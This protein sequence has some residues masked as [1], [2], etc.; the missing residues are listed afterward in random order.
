MRQTSH[1]SHDGAH[2]FNRTAVD[3]FGTVAMLILAVASLVLYFKLTSSGLLGERYLLLIMIGLIAVNV[4]HIVVQVPL[5]RNKLGKL[6]CGVLAVILSAG[7]FWF[8]SDMGNAIDKLDQILGKKLV[9]NREIAVLVRMDDPAQD[10][11]DTFGYRYGYVEGLNAEDTNDLLQHLKEQLGDF[12][13]SASPNPTALVDALYS[14][15]VDAI[16]LPSGAMTQLA[17]MDEYADLEEKT[18]IIYTHTISREV[19]IAV[20]GAEITEP[21]VIYCNGIDSRKSDIHATGNSDVNILAVVNPK[22]REI[23]LLNTPRD[24]YVPLHMNGQN[25][26]LTHAGNYGIEESIGTLSDLYGVEVPY[27]VR[28][29]FYGLVDIVDAIGGVDVESPKEFTTKKMK[30]PG[31]DGNLEKKSFTFP[32]GPIHLNGQEA[33][34]FSRERYAFAS[35]DNQRGKNQMTVISG[36]IDKITSPALLRNYRQILNTLPNAFLTNITFDQVTAL[37]RAQ[38]QDSRKWHVTSYAVSGFADMDYC[39]S[40]PGQELYVTRP[41]PDSVSLA[42]ALIAQVINGE[43]PVLPDS[44]SE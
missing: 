23:L 26:K 40:W 32:A 5:R 14:S 41:D 22:S 44:D 30:I 7:M 4:I 36:I 28:L 9:E 11:G 16:L 8:T 2:R 13:I 20:G 33:L 21:F 24:Y 19:E 6:L 3:H 42:Q 38:Q 1:S 43:T 12:P 31:P 10:L 18:R 15:E 34:A 25:D 35:G 17:D 39:Y 29:N 27:Y 37:V